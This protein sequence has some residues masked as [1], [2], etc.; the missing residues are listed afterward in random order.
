MLSKVIV[1]FRLIAPFTAIA[2]PAE[3]AF[4]L[5]PEPAPAELSVMAIRVIACFDPLVLFS[6]RVGVKFAP[7][8][9]KVNAV[10]WVMV[11]SAT[12]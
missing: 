6:V 12:I 4:K 2:P 11:P 1:P 8:M 5:T 10:V 7:V 3:I 9:L